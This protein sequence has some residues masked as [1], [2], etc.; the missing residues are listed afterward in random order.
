M[1]WLFP[2]HCGLKDPY[3]YLS[4]LELHLLET[5]SW[6]TS[7]ISHQPPLIGLTLGLAQ[8]VAQIFHWLLDVAQTP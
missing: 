6:K 7:A 1:N 2:F 3:M 8:E 5:N 4:N